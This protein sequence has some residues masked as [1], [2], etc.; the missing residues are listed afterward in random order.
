MKSHRVM[1]RIITALHV[2]LVTV[3]FCANAATTNK[4]VGI[5][6]VAVLRATPEHVDVEITGFNDGTL[7]ELSLAATARSADGLIRSS[8]SYP[9]LFPSGRDVRVRARVVAPAGVSIQQTDFLVAGFYRSGTPILFSRLLEWRHSW[10]EASVRKSDSTGTKLPFALSETL[11]EEDFATLDALIE[12]WSNPNHKDS[13]GEFPL[14]NL[15]EAVETFLKHKDWADRLIRIRK[16]HGAN[17]KSAGAAVVEAL[18]WM[19]YAFDARGGEYTT[20]VDAF[21]Q[22]LSLDRLKRAERVL[23]DS[24]GYA[25]RTP[26]WYQTYLQ[27]S[28]SM[29]K[30]VQ[31]TEKLFEASIKHHPSYLPTYIVMMSRWLP[32][33]ASQPNLKKIEEIVNKA[34]ALAPED[35]KPTIYARLFSQLSYAQPDVSSLVKRGIIS[36][37]QMR[38]SAEA[39]VARYPTANNLNMFA[40]FACLADDKNSFL[41]IRPNIANRVVPEMW[42]QNYS[43]DLCQRRFLRYG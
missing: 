28:I 2:S 42:P 37:K 43:L 41:N 29:G 18:Y 3:V 4:A 20:P 23:T 12:K 1:W 40:A 16:W 32:R 19:H 11:N 34:I 39:F 13:D 25:A 8:G 21:A 27:I 33:P 38:D 7:G 22:K 15:N 24:K 17:P 14:K 10:P 5:V 36:W 6:S 26:V 9:V 35:E 30:D 31:F